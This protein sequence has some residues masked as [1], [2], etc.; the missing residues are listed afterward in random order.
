MMKRKP[1]FAVSL[2]IFLMGCVSSPQSHTPR[3]ELLEQQKASLVI[4]KGAYFQNNLMGG[5]EHSITYELTRI[6]T[7]YPNPKERFFYQS[8]TSVMKQLKSFA[9][10]QQDY[11]VLMI[12]PGTYLLENMTAEVGNT[13]IRS[14]TPW[15]IFTVDSGEV[16]YIGDFQ[17]K[18]DKAQK[19]YDLSV[20]DRREEAESY[21]AHHYPDYT[22]KIMKTR[23]LSKA[24]PIQP[25]V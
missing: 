2:M 16:L 11:D 8:K 24:T 21:L 5:R 7:D 6:D 17:F 15:G 4:T 12:Q 23:L 3:L 25:P 22:T 18:F 10:A 20:T 14:S 9:S 13:I 1:F 19:K